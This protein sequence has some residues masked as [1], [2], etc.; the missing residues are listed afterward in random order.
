MVMT[1]WSY[2]VSSIF[3]LF[4]VN[5]LIGGDV[6]QEHYPRPRL[7]AVMAQEETG[8]LPRPEGLEYFPPFVGDEDHKI[9]LTI[10][11]SYRIVEMDFSK[12]TGKPEEP[13]GIEDAWGDIGK[14]Q[15]QR[16][17]DYWRTK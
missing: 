11:A 12:I 15:M 16:L 14:A 17:E 10:T 13:E 5:R 7:R 4:G 9:P 8:R 3:R 1:I 2:A 6:T